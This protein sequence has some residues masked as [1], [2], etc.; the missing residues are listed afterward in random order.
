M[1]K[2]T[3]NPTEVLRF[4]KWMYIISKY[5]RQYR[6]KKVR[7]MISNPK[8]RILDI[9]CSDTS[10]VDS[11]PNPAICADMEPKEGIDKQDICQ[12]TYKDKEFDCSIAL[13][14]LEHCPDPVKAMTEL[15]RVTKSCIIISVPY[16]PFFSIPKLMMW[17]PQH[18][19]AIRPQALKYHLG[20]PQYETKIFFKRYY[21]AIWRLR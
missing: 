3:I 21:L 16:E 6:N 14:V 11:L 4:P 1:D 20:T 10:L 19:W 15:E 9:G 18:W 8:W 2:K 13:E 7:A 17:E 12:L 5:I